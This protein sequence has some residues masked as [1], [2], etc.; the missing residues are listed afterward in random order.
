[1]KIAIAV[2]A[3]LAFFV[4]CLFASN[5]SACNIGCYEYQGICACDAKPIALT[6]SEETQPSDEKP[7]RSQQP[8]WQTGGVT[9]DSPKSQA[10]SDD[11]ADKA[12]EKA[13]AEGKKS[14][15]L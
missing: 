13:D 15:G 1:M 5:A 7:R 9:A 12:K 10:V 11:N 3:F 14:A 6:P 8:E 4:V 2:L